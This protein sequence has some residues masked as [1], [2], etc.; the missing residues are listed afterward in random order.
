MFF[1]HREEVDGL[2]P[3]KDLRPLDPPNAADAEAEELSA[4]GA[5]L[6]M[7]R[8]L[9]RL[10]NHTH[11][12]PSVSSKHNLELMWPLFFS[13]AERQRTKT[14]HGCRADGNEAV[15]APPPVSS[16]AIPG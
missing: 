15:S 11:A 6:A 16:S 8:F 10:H 14:I 4:V 12:C 9:S 7:V 1:V 2:F 5:A 13:T 3:I